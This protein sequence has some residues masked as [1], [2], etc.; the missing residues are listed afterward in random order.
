MRVQLSCII[1]WLLWVRNRYEDIIT[2]GDRCRL[3]LS[4]DTW[5]G[6][7]VWNSVLI[8]FSEVVLLFLLLFPLNL[9]LPVRSQWIL[10]KPIGRFVFKFARTFHPKYNWQKPMTGVR[11]PPWALVA[12]HLTRT[13]Q[14]VDFIPLCLTVRLD[15]AAQA[16]PC[17]KWSQFC[18]ISSKGWFHRGHAC[19]CLRNCL[20]DTGETLWSCCSRK[21][22]LYS[23]L[24]VFLKIV[25]H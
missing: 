4:R 15:W 23:I 9:L 24:C 5:A 10:T 2:V 21:Q 14:F 8:A 25:L 12:L 18:A 6:G 19:S 20:S 13:S 16:R 11:K 7:A 22:S 17:V 3:F 1:C